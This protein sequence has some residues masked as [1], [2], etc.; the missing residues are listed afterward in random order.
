MS[1]CL[2]PYLPDASEL[3]RPPS[4][5]ER[6]D[7]SVPCLSLRLRFFPSAQAYDELAP[8]LAAFLASQGAPGSVTQATAVVVSEAL[9]NAVDHGLLGLDSALKTSFETF[10]AERGAR[11]G[12]D[13]RGAV[14]LLAVVHRAAGGSFSHVWI[15]VTDPGQGF[16]W[17]SQM[18]NSGDPG[19]LPHG[20]GLTL[21]RALARDLS[22]ND[23]GNVIS[24][25]IYSG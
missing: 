18:A 17:R 16:D 24:F 11:L 22:F 15:Q 13:P 21:I 19:T 14:E 10:E 1:W 2:W 12:G 25:S 4:P 8:N 6:T 3:A 7:A 23:A 20:R 5:T 9:M